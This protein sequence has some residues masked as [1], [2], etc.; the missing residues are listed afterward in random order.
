[1]GAFARSFSA[2]AGPP[3]RHIPPAPPSTCRRAY[4]RAPLATMAIIGR[5]GADWQMTPPRTRCCA[6]R[7]WFHSAP[8]NLIHYHRTRISYTWCHRQVLA[9][10]TKQTSRAGPRREQRSRPQFTWQSTNL[11]HACRTS[12]F[13]IWT[14]AKDIQPCPDLT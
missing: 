13:G 7:S 8:P 6:Q 11:G 5:A 9:V 2:A 4:R 12:S 1:M 14:C 3:A 10:N